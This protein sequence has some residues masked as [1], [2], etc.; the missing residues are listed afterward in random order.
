LHAALA[1]TLPE[2]ES[3]RTSVLNLNPRTN[4]GRLWQVWPWIT[5]FVPVIEMFP[6]FPQ[7]WSGIA[8]CWTELLWA[9]LVW[10][11]FGGAMTRMHAVRFAG[12]GSVSP[13][14]AVLFSGRLWS[15]YLYGP[16]L[17]MLGVGALSLIGLGVGALDSSLGGGRGGWL[18]ALGW[19]PML[20]GFLMAALLV[21]LAAS[22]PLMVAA[23]SAEGSDGFDGLSRSF[24][25]VMNRP[26]SFVW[27]VGLAFGIGV[28]ANSFVELF[29]TFAFRLADW[30]TGVNDGVR[31]NHQFEHWYEL[32]PLLQLAVMVSYFWSATTVIYLLLRQSDDGTPLDQVYIP[33]PPPKAEPLPLVGVATSQQPVIE[34]P[35]TESP[36][37]TQ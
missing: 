27:L 19:L 16:L 9:L 37:T 1:A 22:W 15:N 28:L 13:G 17:P 3:V 34:R 12:D 18:L 30:S 20:A 6:S 11:I 23:I 8:V 4:E 5:V 7:S 29:L 2:R 14:H 26:W 25:Y 35:A 24:G 31:I 21:L 32:V 10:A 36:Q 33:G